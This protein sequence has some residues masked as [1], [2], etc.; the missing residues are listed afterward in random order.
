MDSG[1][2]LSCRNT[3]EARRYRPARTI[4]SGSKTRGARA[5]LVFDAGART[6]LGMP[7]RAPLRRRA[8]GLGPR[9]TGRLVASSL[10]KWPAGCESLR[11]TTCDKTQRYPSHQSLG[12]NLGLSDPIN[13]SES[14]SRIMSEGWL[15]GSGVGLKF[16]RCGS[17]CSFGTECRQTLGKCRFAGDSS[18]PNAPAQVLVSARQSPSG[19]RCAA[20]GR[21]RPRPESRRDFSNLSGGL[22]SDAK[23]L[24]TFHAV[25]A[26]TK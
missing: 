1:L 22:Q 14:E 6:V 2:A 9:S 8:R 3:S 4:A 18:P 21:G 20:S 11:C 24:A 7:S 17:R 16:H 5:T 23:E 13:P 25:T 15:I 26:A 10:G 19:R 12:R